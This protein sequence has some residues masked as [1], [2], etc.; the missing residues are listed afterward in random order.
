MKKAR[1]LDTIQ[2][3]KTLLLGID[4]PYNKTRNMQAYFDEFL[5]LV[6]S[7][8]IP[9]DET[10]FIKI[11]SVDAAYFLTKGKLEEVRELCER[12]EIEEIIVSE[13]LSAQQE[14]NLSELF[15][16]KVFDRTQLILEIFE[17]SAHSAEGKMQVAIA[18]FNHQKSRVAGKGLHMSQQAGHIGGRGPGETAKE[19]ELRHL[20]KQITKFKSDLKDIQKIRENQ[21]KRRL[22]NRVPHICL[23][24]YTNTGKSTILNELTNAQVLA[25]DQLFATLDTTTRELYINGTKKGIISDTVGFIQQLPHQL[26]DAFKSTLAE[27]QYAD[28]LLQVVDS[29][30]SS[31]K[32][33]IH[34]VQKILN[35][36]GVH[37]DMVY[38]F[39]KM[40]I[41][42]EHPITEDQLEL[43]TPHVIVSA[44]SKKGIQPLVDFLATWEKK[45]IDQ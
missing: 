45:E 40:D 38:V 22:E 29:A 13:P 34:V 10:C 23:I 30:D 5:H 17:K 18:M 2:Y 8:A 15:H 36:L 7:N 1:S 20:E 25:A 21:R 3:P 26:I 41:P 43:F 39:N 14:R 19:K 12:E 28:L 35:E 9:F 31:W 4:A 37:K 33:H 11:R 24:G 32:E 16:A 27:L 6:K 42:T 44:K